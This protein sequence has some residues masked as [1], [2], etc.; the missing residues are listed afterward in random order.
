MVEWY[1]YIGL[2]V[3][4]LICRVEEQWL[5]V[6]FD[7]FPFLSVREMRELRFKLCLSGSK[8]LVLLSLG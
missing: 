1:I 8:G 4:C 2:R 6:Q 3:A 7:F 5:V